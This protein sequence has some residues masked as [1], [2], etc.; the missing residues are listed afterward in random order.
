MLLGAVTDSRLGERLFNHEERHI[1]LAF[2][3]CYSLEQG[4]PLPLACYRLTDL[5]MALLL[6][7][8]LL[9]HLL[10]TCLLAC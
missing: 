5:L 1:I 8:Y 2:Y 10:S 7:F 4:Y 9:L 3:Q 6:A